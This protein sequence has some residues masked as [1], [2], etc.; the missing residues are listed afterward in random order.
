MTGGQSNVGTAA[1]RFHEDVPHRFR[2]SLTMSM[3]TRD[4]VSEI[5]DRL[6]DEAG[7]RTLTTDDVMRLALL[8]AA[9]YHA[10]ATG[11]VEPDAPVDDEELVPLTAAVRRTLGEDDRVPSLD[12]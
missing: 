6:N 3:D 9:R 7:A 2:V 1:D 10:V 11:D 4:A 12:G 5:R 8:A